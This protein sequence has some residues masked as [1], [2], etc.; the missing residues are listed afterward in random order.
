MERDRMVVRFELWQED[1]VALDG[2]IAEATSKLRH[3]RSSTSHIGSRQRRESCGCVSMRRVMKAIAPPLYG[4]WERRV[5]GIKP[6]AHAGGPPGSQR[7]GPS[8]TSPELGARLHFTQ[9][10]LFSV[11]MLFFARSHRRGRSVTIIVRG[12]EIERGDCGQVSPRF[13]VRIPNLTET[14]PNAGLV[15]LDS[16]PQFGV[17]TNCASIMHQPW[18]ELRLSSWRSHGPADS[19]GAEEAPHPSSRLH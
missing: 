13:F 1:C 12:S 4:R 2:R 11:T 5:P 3:S 16:S 14:L 8:S 15:A 7:H 17:F 6:L 9:L 18:Q 19:A 10:M